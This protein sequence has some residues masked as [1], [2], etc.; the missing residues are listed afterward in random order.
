[1][2]APHRATDVPQ[3][4]QAA[5]ALQLQHTNDKRPLSTSGLKPGECRAAAKEPR[6]VLEGSGGQQGGLNAVMAEQ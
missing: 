2:Q 6:S 3:T 5:R 1:M 4:T